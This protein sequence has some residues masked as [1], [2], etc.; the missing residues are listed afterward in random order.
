MD[1]V[2]ESGDEVEALTKEATSDLWFP[3]EQEP[4]SQVPPQQPDIVNSPDEENLERILEIED[5]YRKSPSPPTIR[6]RKFQSKVI[7][8]DSDSMEELPHMRIP[9]KK[10]HACTVCQKEFNSLNALKYHCLSHTGER[11]H[12][13]TVCRKSFF[14]QSALKSHMRLHTGEKPYECDQCKMKFRQWG[15]LKYH[16]VSKHS[17]VKNYQ[18]EFCGK[19]FSRKYSLVIHRRIHTN[20]RNY[21]CDICGKSFRA[22]MYL[23]SHRKIHTG[24]LFQ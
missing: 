4:T 18:C 11:A 10:T 2:Q 15:D 23:T 21:K 13:C 14:A 7:E 20:E 1:K 24:E 5:L 17:D 12:T 22:S 19:A 8:S 3:N 9:K 16:T 6:V